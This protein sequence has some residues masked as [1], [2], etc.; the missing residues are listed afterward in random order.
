MS[1]YISFFFPHTVRYTEI[2]TLYSVLLFTRGD[3]IGDIDTSVQYMNIGNC[4]SE[5]LQLRLKNSIFIKYQSNSYI[6]A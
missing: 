1:N 5:T 6:F 2:C 4:C 3:N